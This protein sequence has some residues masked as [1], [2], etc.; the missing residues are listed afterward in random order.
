MNYSFRVGVIAALA[1]AP[2]FTLVGAQGYSYD[3]TNSGTDPRSG[4]AQVI[5][6]SHGRW[7]KDMTRIDIIESPARGGMMGKGTYMIAVGSTGITTF[8]DPAK[9]QYYELN[10]K[11]MAMEATD[12]QGAIAGM[13]KMEVVDIHVDME[14]SGA[15][16]PIAGYATWKY[17]LTESYT[18]RMTV[19]GHATDTKE[20]MVSDLWVAPALIGNLN[21]RSRPAASANGMM[22]ALTEATYKAYAKIK[23]GV[24]LRMINT[25]E[26]GEGARAR[27]HVTTMNVSNFKRESFNADVFQ[28][29]TGYTKVDSPF[30]ALNAGK[31]P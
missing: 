14:D 29:P 9:K 31:K 5:S 13:A 28:L 27:S 15:G 4:N 18:M 2:A 17:R 8:V 16:E 22:Q 1:I 20:H 19:L 6:S 23:P 21:P 3:V 30:D 26:S 10:S 25:S 7:E 11:E 12:L 24:M